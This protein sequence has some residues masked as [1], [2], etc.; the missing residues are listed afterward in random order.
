MDRKIRVLFIC[1]R[2]AAR[3]Q[4]AEGYL[5]HRHGD[6]FE[7]FSAGTRASSVSPLAVRVMAEKGIDIS[8]HR[9]KD[10][11][12]FTGQEMDLAVSLC[13]E[14]VCPFFPWAREIA[15]LRLPDPGQF[16]GDEEIRL[17]KFRQLRDT[18]FSWIDALA[19]RFPDVRDAP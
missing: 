10:L 6:R 19:G 13:D 8:D 15:H 4:M 18:I 7:A 11:G 17:Q 14:G 9:S 16:G 1:S 3:S 5:R 12:I 2:N